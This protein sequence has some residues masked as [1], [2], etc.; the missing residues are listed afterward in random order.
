MK[1]LRELK[2]EQEDKV[3]NLIKEC[4]VF[5]AFSDEQFAKNKTDLLPGEKY[6]ALG[7]G[8]YMPKGKVD[9]YIQGMKSIHKWFKEAVRDNKLRRQTIEYALHNHEALYTGEIEDALE[10]LGD[11]YSAEEVTDVL[12]SLQAA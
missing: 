8:V 7:N 4:L 1:N 11:D 6:A 12:R 5:F 3:T 10:E 9:S 2:K